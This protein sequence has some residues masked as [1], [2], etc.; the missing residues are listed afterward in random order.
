MHRILLFIFLRN[1]SSPAGVS[2]IFVSNNNI[3]VVATVVDRGASGLNFNDATHRGRLPLCL[4]FD[5][6]MYIVYSIC[7][8]LA[9]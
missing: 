8:L 9:P 6:P 1:L 7:S 3:I 4:W 2:C 5:I